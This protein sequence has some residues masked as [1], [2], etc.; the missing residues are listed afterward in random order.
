MQDQ[1]CAINSAAAIE[2]AAAE[3]IMTTMRRL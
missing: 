2:Y 3:F 1:I